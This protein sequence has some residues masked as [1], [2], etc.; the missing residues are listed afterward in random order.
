MVMVVNNEATPALRQQPGVWP[1]PTGGSDDDHG[2]SRHADWRRL[3]ADP[4]FDALIDM[5]GDQDCADECAALVE[6]WRD[7]RRIARVEA[8]IG[9]DQPEPRTPHLR[10]LRYALTAEAYARAS[11]LKPWDRYEERLA[12][13]VD[14]F[15]QEALGDRFPLTLDDVREWASEH[16]VEPGVADGAV[17]LPKPNGYTSGGWYRAGGTLE[18]LA[19]LAD[20]LVEQFHWGIDVKAVEFVLCDRV[21]IVSPIETSAGPYYVTLRVHVD[22]GYDEVADAYR[23]ARSVFQH[24][25]RAKSLG[26]RTLRAAGFSALRWQREWPDIY[27]EWCRRYGSDD[28]YADW[29]AFRRAVVTGLR[30]I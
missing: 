29:R 18:R 16:E 12:E 23:E 6:R 21:P 3:C 15:R 27:G 10:A 9:T 2:R 24:G 7:E 11:G 26:E 28:E 17:A 1:K 13:R 5:A 8:A 22:A 14:R 19:K 20:E 25:A 30:A 4:A